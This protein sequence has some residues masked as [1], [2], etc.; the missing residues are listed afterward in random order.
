MKHH[1]SI[2]LIILI[3]IFLI[4]FVSNAAGFSL[5]SSLAKR[6]LGGKIIKSGQSAEIACSTP[7]GPIFMR[8]FNLAISGPFF[9]RS[10]TGSFIN[11]GKYL[12]GNYNLIPDLGT[13]YNPE[14]GAPIPAFEIKPYGISQ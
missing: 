8:P 7:S 5:S 6:P 3:L 11:S 12:L 13:C 2:V 4:P 14:T 10:T 9:I 1:K